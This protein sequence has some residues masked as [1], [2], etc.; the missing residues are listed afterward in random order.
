MNDWYVLVLLRV[1]R[2]SGPSMGRVGSCR[3]ELVHKILRLRLAGLGRIRCQKYLIN[4]QL[5]CKKFVDYH[6]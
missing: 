5:T 4:M 1:G 6:S 2:E 3:V